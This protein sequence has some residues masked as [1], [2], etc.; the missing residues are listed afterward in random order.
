MVESFIAWIVHARYKTTITMLEE[1]REKTI[2]RI[3]DFGE[4]SKTRTTDISPII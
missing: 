4:F 2:K 1:M 3:G